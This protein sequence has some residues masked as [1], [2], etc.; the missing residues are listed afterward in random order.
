MSKPSEVL[1]L[2]LF[3]LNTIP[4]AEIDLVRQCL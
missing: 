4:E 1:L 2:I 3:Y